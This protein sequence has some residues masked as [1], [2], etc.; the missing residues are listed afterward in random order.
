[1]SDEP[2]RKS[3]PLKARTAWALILLFVMYWA[4][5]GPIAFLAGADLISG[6]TD[7]AINVIYVPLRPLHRVPFLLRLAYL[8]DEWWYDLGGEWR[9]RR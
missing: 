6:E 8:Y 3:P 1:M 9:S 7:A 2:M 4:S 5:A